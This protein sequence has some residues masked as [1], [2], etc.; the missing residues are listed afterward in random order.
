MHEPADERRAEGQGI[1]GNDQGRGEAHE[2]DHLPHAALAEAC[3]AGQG[4]QP[5][6]DH[7]EQGHGIGPLVR[8]G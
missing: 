4:Q 5:Q 1:G 8:V 2:A 7:V 3:K 6:G